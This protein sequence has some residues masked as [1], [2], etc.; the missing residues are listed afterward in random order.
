MARTRVIFATRHYPGTRTLKITAYLHAYF[1]QPK[2]ALSVLI[3]VCIC[4]AA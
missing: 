3:I 4:A 1:V 2:L